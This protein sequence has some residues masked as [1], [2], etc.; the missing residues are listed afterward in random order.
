[1]SFNT[2]KCHL[3][4]SKTG[5]ALAFE[6]V[7]SNLQKLPLAKIQNLISV[8]WTCQANRMKVKLV[9][10]NDKITIF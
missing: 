8:V 4:V 5:N 2:A 3:N 1:M 9:L 6:K 10:K 7:V